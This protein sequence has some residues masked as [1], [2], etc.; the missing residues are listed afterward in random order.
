MKKLVSWILTFAMLFSLC[1][2]AFAADNATL[3]VTGDSDGNI[4]AGDV[5]EVTV[6]VRSSAR[7][8]WTLTSPTRMSMNGR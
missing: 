6:T 8:N 1:S 2:T 3:T 5:L 4:K 7:Q